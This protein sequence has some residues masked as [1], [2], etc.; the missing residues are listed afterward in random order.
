MAASHDSIWELI[1]WYVNGSLPPAEAD[2]V[3]RHSSGCQICAAEI[4]CQRRLA[5]SVAKAEP[6]DPPLDLARNWENLRAQIEAA[7]AS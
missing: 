7:R 2:A 3:R 1:P 4:K 6:F 5:K